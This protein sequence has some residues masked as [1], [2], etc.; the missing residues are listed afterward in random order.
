MMPRRLFRRGHRGQSL[1]EFALILPVFIMVTVGIVDAG[2]AIYSYNT[3]ANSARA[4]AR[5]AIV[6]QDAT[7]IRNAAIA[8]APGL[9]LTSADVVLV[10]CAQLDCKYSVTVD[11]DFAPVTPFVSE[12][13]NPVISSTAEMRVEFPNP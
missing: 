5:V 7:D 2:R 9:G 13:F 1:T 3:V 12:I 10:P 6:N 11:Y 8:A 4:A